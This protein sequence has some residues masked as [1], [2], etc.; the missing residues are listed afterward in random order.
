MQNHKISV[1]LF[2]A[3]SSVYL[4]TATADTVAKKQPANSGHQPSLAAKASFITEFD[5][6]SDD[7]VSQAEFNLIRQQRYQQMDQHKNQQVTAVD[8]QTEYADRLDRKLKQERDGQIQQTHTRVKAL[9]KDQDGAISL[10]EYQASGER[11]FAFLD[12]NKDLQINKQDPA[13]TQ[14]TE[15]PAAANTSAAK[16]TSAK[17]EQA[18]ARTT[19]RPNSVLKMPTSHNLTGMLEMYDQNQDG[20][21]SKAEY[22]EQR[23]TAFN[24]TD[25]NS[26][27]VLSADEYLNEF[28]DRLDRQVASVRTSQLKQALVRFKALDKDENSWL[29]Q[30]EYDASGARM[31]K[32][33]DTSGD[34][35]VTMAEVLPK[36]EAA[37]Q[38]AE[39]TAAT[40]KAGNAYNAKSRAVTSDQSSQ[41][42]A[43]KPN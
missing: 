21:V 6:N 30:A 37:P 43:V 2:L 14:R 38:T 31:F 17:P 28:V 25:V 3:L 4:Q 15:R 35:T 16:S 11:A 9:D 10:A 39:K 42:V 23:Q 1:A 24:R 13:P 5:Q 12:T 26:D 29:S 18:T 20:L 41:D 40:D 27:G 34:A 36:A 22:L 33:W 7:N 8:Y 32:R 19:V